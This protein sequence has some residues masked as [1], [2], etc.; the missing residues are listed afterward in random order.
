MHYLFA[1]V[2]SIAITGQI[3][4]QSELKVFHSSNQDVL[5]RQELDKYLTAIAFRCLDQRKEMVAGI[6]SPEEVAKWQRT[7][8][9][10]MFSMLGPVPERTP[11]RAG[12]VGEIERDGYKVQKLLFQSIAGFFVPALVYV[13][14]D[15][16]GPF[17]AVVS[18]CGH[19]ILGKAY[20]TYQAVHVGFVRRGFLVISYDPPGQ[21]ERLEY[22]MERAGESRFLRGTSTTEHTMSGIQCWLT[23]TSEASYFIWDGMRAIDYLQS[24]SDVDPARIAVTGNSGGGNLT[25]YIAALDDRVSVAVPSCY[26]TSW[27]QLW[28]TIGPQD[29]EQNLLP[30]IASGL[31]FGDYIISFAPKPY[32][33]NTAIRDFFSIRGARD[34]YAEVSRIYEILG[35]AENFSKFEADDEHGYTLP[36]REAAYKWIGKHLLDNPPPSTEE[37]FQ[38]LAEDELRVTRTGQLSTSIPTARTIREINAEYAKQIFPVFPPL[39]SEKAINDYRR[40][41]ISAV[42]SLAGIRRNISTRLNYQYMGGFERDGIKIKLFTF[43]PEPGI[44]LPAVL[45]LPVSPKNG[46]EAVVFVDNN[47]SDN[48]YGEALDFARLGH[49][50]ITFDLRGTGETMTGGGDGSFGEWFSDN[51]E[52]ALKSLHVNK[53]LAGQRA[54][55]IIRCLDLADSL[56]PEELGSAF[57]YRLVARNIATVPAL[58][59]AVGDSRITSLVLDHGLISWMNLVGAEMHRQQLD[60]VVPGALAAYD[61]PR[62]AAAFTPRR[63]IF[64]DPVDPMGHPI[65]LEQ[66]ETGLSDALIT[67]EKFGGDKGLSIVRRMPEIS[68]AR[69]IE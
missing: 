66:A 26:I 31:D 5:A 6:N 48:F 4:A 32:M 67:Y 59:A 44:T 54:V 8:R 58:H 27:H 24:R 46:A 47:K 23:G 38:P 9:R 49:P 3:F 20:S 36:R 28:Q 10:K 1:F 19:H 14:T 42:D 33:M 60:N 30:M 11:V 16:E 25:A 69:T 56:L 55:D 57:K 18:P 15:R 35:A 13:P 53:P 7:I 22:F 41:L 52:I 51:Y 61:L 43:D 50:A 37:P 45:C 21:G 39:E 2:V 62:L 12:I 40:W 34:T 17:P 63:L 29:A 64:I 68:I 65:D